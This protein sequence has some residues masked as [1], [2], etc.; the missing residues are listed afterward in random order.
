[1]ERPIF[2]IV[3]TLT[4]SSGYLVL[5]SSLRDLAVSLKSSMIPF[6]ALT[7]KLRLTSSLQTLPLT[8]S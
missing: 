4:K 2:S 6:K 7:W 8:A 3:L 1:M 5:T